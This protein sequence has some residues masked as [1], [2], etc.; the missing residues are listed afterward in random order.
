MGPV[1]HVL[2][3]GRPPRDDALTKTVGIA[4]SGFHVVDKEDFHEGLATYVWLANGPRSIYSSV[5]LV[6]KVVRQGIV[7]PRGSSGPLDDVRERGD[8]DSTPHEWQYSD[9]IAVS[10]TPRRHGP[11]A[12][13]TQSHGWKKR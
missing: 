1:R 4:R 3:D 8:S 11:T 5:C 12:F 13:S 2:V 7:V 6:H 9:S 10:T